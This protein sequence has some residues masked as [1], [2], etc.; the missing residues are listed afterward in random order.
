MTVL[1]QTNAC[2]TVAI[3]SANQLVGLGLQS[4]FHAWPHIQFIGAA[5]SAIEAEQ[6]VSRYHPQVLLI[7]WGSGCGT[8]QLVQT[9]KATAPETRLIALIRVD[10]A[11]HG[12]SKG[13]RYV[14]WKPSVRQ[15][16]QF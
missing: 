6:V 12:G 7:E 3:V 10:G 9:L 5:A 8:L 13:W 14:L 1:D 16:Q 15:H 2:I 11:M 4:V